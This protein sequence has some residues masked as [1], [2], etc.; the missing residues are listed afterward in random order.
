MSI[1]KSRVTEPSSSHVHGHHHQPAVFTFNNKCDV[2]ETSIESL[3]AQTPT[4]T[5]KPD[6]ECDGIVASAFSLTG[7]FVKKYHA[8]SNRFALRYLEYC[9]HVLHWD[10][11]HSSSDSEAEHRR[12]KAHPTRYAHIGELIGVYPGKYVDR[13]ETN[14]AHKS[15]TSVRCMTIVIWRM[16]A[17]HMVDFECQNKASRDQWADDINLMVRLYYARRRIN[18]FALS[19]GGQLIQQYIDKFL[20]AQGASQ[21]ETTLHPHDAESEQNNNN[22]N[23]DRIQKLQ[24]ETT[25]HTD[26]VL[27]LF[28]VFSFP[29]F[30][31]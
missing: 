26:T 10:T 6:C 27:S 18:S 22:N 31:V 9:A 3:S 7:Q 21:P 16:N 24:R 28:S 4:L 8:N 29:L 23:N 1:I 25:V 19:I 17:M 13:F 30:C 2:S 11:R 5:C 12:M 20:F 14:V 15:A